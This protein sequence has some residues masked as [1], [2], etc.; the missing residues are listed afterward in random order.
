MT[1]T[2]ASEVELIQRAAQ[3]YSDAFGD[4]VR[5]H[6][7]LFHNGINRILGNTAD[8][9][10]AHRVL[11]EEVIPLYYDHDIDGLPRHWIKRMMNSIS[12][13]AWR[14]SADRMVADYVRH[15]YLPASG[16]LSCDMGVR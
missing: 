10:D 2:P 8:A 11:T 13:L 3:G 6:L 1:L 9:Q 12:S 15:C 16:G 7:A 5:P 14:F 4:L